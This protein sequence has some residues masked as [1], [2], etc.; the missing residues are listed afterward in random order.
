MVASRRHGVTAFKVEVDENSRALRARLGVMSTFGAVGASVIQAATSAVIENVAVS[1]EGERVTLDATT[2]GTTLSLTLR[3][4][5]EIAAGARIQS[6]G[7]RGR[8]GERRRD[9]RRRERAPRSAPSMF[10]RRHGY[11]RR[12]SNRSR[13]RDGVSRTFA[14][15]RRADKQ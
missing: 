4:D 12:R 15:R 2:R 7:R 8:D 11:V 6:L 5:S 3:R 9:E 14:R 13:V 10:L 1:N